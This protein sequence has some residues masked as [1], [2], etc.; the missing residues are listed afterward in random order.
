MCSALS[1][2]SASQPILAQLVLLSRPLTKEDEMTMSS[3]RYLFSIL[4]VLCF[5]SAC[6]DS[7]SGAGLETPEILPPEPELLYRAE[8]R[9]TD[10]GIPHIKADDWGGLGYGYGYAYSQDNFCVTMREIVFAAGRSAELMG[11]EEGNTES[12]FLVRYLIGSKEK[13]KQD[14]FDQLPA[15]VRELAQGT[16]A[17]MNRYLA[18]TGV[19]NLAEGEQGCRNASW[20]AAI[21]AV[22]LV[23]YQSREA[24]RGS[25]QEGTFRRAILATTGPDQQPQASASLRQVQRAAPALRQFAQQI[26]PLDRGSNGIAL[27]GNATQTGSGM[28]LGNPHQ[29]WQGAGSW[30]QAHLTIPGVYDAAGATLT[31][32]P[33]IGLGFNKDLAWTH[34]VSRANRFSLYELTL[35]PDNPLQYDYEGEWRDIVPEEIEIQVRLDDGILETRSHTYYTSHYGPVVNLGGISSL[36]DGWPM[37]TGTVLAFRDANLTTGVRG[38]ELWINK[39]QATN[40]DEYIAALATIGNPVFHDLAADRHGD[41]FYGEISSIPFVTKLQLESCVDGVIGPLLAGETSN[42][43]ISLNGSRAECE[44]GDD[45]EAPAGSNVYGA[46]SLPQLR[47]RDYVANSNNSYWLS[48]PNQ[49]LTGFPTIMGPV[50]YEGLQQFQ[51]TRINHLMVAERL[52]GTDG[53]DDAPGFTLDSLERL[54]YENRVYGAEIV[55]D[56]VL[57][58]CA[59]MEVIIQQEDSVPSRALEACAVLAQ[60]DRKADLESRGLQVYTEFWR[61]IFNEFSGFQGVVES[62][63]LWAQDFEPSDPL[64]TPAGIDSGLEANQERVINALSNAV[65]VLRE[66]NVPLDA[67]WG[68]VQY[69]ERNGERVPIHG[70]LGPLAIFGAIGVSLSEGGYIN[71]GAGNSYIQAVTWDETECPVADVIISHSNSS[72]PA[73]DHYSD[74]SKLYS[75]KEWVRFPFCED[76]IT[77]AQIGETLTIEE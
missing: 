5:V 30:Y 7:D 23:L 58:I 29:P 12:D 66:A 50:G 35:N 20:V 9:R 2:I 51:R 70:G 56:D 43:I 36:F 67:P 75:N 55:L 49:P 69:L 21:D 52:A 74:Q 38:I 13:F 57:A 46:S 53:F 11:E 62:D 37:F 31:G 32:Y 14:F 40:M 59:G 61:S 72:D 76:E 71:P 39:A 48:N 33:F 22:D 8:I 19:E 10:Y 73:S 44:W 28:V 17:G 42:V 4:V 16:A 3:L 24:L 6:S 34:T 77:A 41:A 65:V 45:P 18:E 26:L 47:T 25:S 68:E 1:E 64:N 60:W 15:Y 27:G 54:M 63:E